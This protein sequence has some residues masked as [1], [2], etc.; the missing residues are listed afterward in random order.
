MKGIICS[1]VLYQAS[2]GLAQIRIGADPF[3]GDFSPRAKPLVLN[4]AKLRVSL[5][6]D[7]PVYFIREL[8]EVTITVTNPTA[9]MLEIRAPFD[10][11]GPFLELRGKNPKWVQYYG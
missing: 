3:N 11:R 9:D 2:F 7:R 4:E 1:F 10:S 5:K 8:A 6:M